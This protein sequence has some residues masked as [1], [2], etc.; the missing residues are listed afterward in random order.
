M[1]SRAKLVVAAVALASAGAVA[2]WH[3]A[4]ER[5]AGVGGFADA[6]GVVHD[7]ADE[8]VRHAVFGAPE[9][10]AGDV[11]SA[12]DELRATR[13]ADGR[14]IVFAVGRRGSNMELWIAERD[15]DGVRPPRL[16]AALDTEADECAPSFGPGALWFASDRPGGAGGLDLYRAAF[17]GES[18]GA[19]ERCDEALQSPRDDTDPAPIPGT[20]EIAFASDRSGAFALYHTRALEGRIDVSS[21]AGQPAGAAREPCF[22]KDGR[23][24]WF[25]LET[26][27]RSDILRARVDGVR[28]AGASAVPGLDTDAD[29]RAPLV[30]DDGFEV[31]FARSAP[32]TRGYDLACARSQE[33]LLVPPIAWT[34]FEI[35]TIAALIVLAALAFLADRFAALDTI[36]RCYLASVIV[37]LFLALWL[38]HVFVE[39]GESGPRDTGRKVR[40]KLAPNASSLTNARRERAGDVSDLVAGVQPS[41]SPERWQGEPRPDHDA[42]AARTIDTS[43]LEPAPAAAPAAPARDA[44][45]AASPRAG[46]TSRE[47]LRDVEARERRLQLPPGDDLEPSA[48]ATLPARSTPARPARGAFE[49]NETAA[50]A[51]PVPAPDLAE[52]SRDM[53]RVAL[54]APVAGRH[55]VAPPARV[56]ASGAAVQDREVSPR[57]RATE[58]APPRESDLLEGLGSTTASARP[59]ASPRRAAFDAG[60]TTNDAPSPP[61]L[62]SLASAPVPDAPPPAPERSDWSGTPYANRAAGAKERALLDHGGSAETE[63]AVERGLEYLASVQARSGNF[64]PSSARDDKYGQ[65]AVGKTGLATL[66][67]LG[68]GHTHVSGTRWSHVTARALTYLLSIQDERNGHFGD[69][70]AYGH[71]IATYTLAEAYALTKDPQLRAPL[72]R[73]VRR[74]VAAQSHARDARLAGGWSYYFADDHVFDRWSRA[75]I[76][77]W[78]VM[79]LESARLGGIE[80]EDRVF[81]DAAKFLDACRDPDE[82]WFRYSHD[83]ARLGSGY[84]TLPASTPAGLFALS[85]LGRDIEG[86]EYR[87]E[88]RFVVE[89]APRGFRYTNEAEFVGR[90]Q[91]NPYFHYYGTLAMFRAGGSAWKAWN[92]AL[93]SSLLPAQNADGS[94][95]PLDAYARYARDDEDDKSYTTALCVL[96]LEVYYRYYL[97]LLKAGAAR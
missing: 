63:R 16:I 7:V 17:D 37:H 33:I 60:S 11:N 13:S 28:L 55:P 36:Y 89:R 43:E 70:D 93:K 25:A 53:T 27:G 14:W 72:E 35:V 65:I 12:A 76:T 82:D 80:I 41:A 5:S 62:E 29:E 71:G 59:A 79:A 88:R 51:P 67:F 90:G 6:H 77:A 92:Q 50:S 31:V 21:Y 38:Q 61:A 18:F 54:D 94:W 86:D 42:P 73:A 48:L 24:L 91:G 57:G 8:G 44:A 56:P 97:P 47:A 78:Q 58:P 96:S 46:T 64:G 15:G 40:V 87:A 26:A 9:P 69:G 39:P 1:K 22:S 34:W 49:A 74:I 75:S 81:D 66:A 2:A 30:I 20:S 95:T 45:L 10:L 23:M 4:R 83:P 84:P 68:A 19:A 3:A 52:L 85:I 32:D